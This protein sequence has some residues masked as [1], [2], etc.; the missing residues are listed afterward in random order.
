MKIRRLLRDI[1]EDFT[2]KTGEILRF[3]TKVGAYNF[4]G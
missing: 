1:P 3:P 4:T 2:N